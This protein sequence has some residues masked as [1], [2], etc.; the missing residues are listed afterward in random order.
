MNKKTNEFRFPNLGKLLKKLLVL[1]N[2]N[3][4]GITRDDNDAS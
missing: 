2:I 1:R 4:S 3:F